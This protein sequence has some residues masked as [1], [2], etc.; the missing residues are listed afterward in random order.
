[1]AQPAHAAPAS[2]LS[3]DGSR[4]GTKAGPTEAA[5]LD[6]AVTDAKLKD[7]WLLKFGFKSQ[8][9]VRYEPLALFF[10]GGAASRE[11]QQALEAI[12]AERGALQACVGAA[13]RASRAGGPASVG[14]RSDSGSAR[15]CAGL[16]VAT[17]LG[18]AGVRVVVLSPQVEVD[19]ALLLA[20]LHGRPIVSA[21]W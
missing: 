12:A 3:P 18:Q 1:M 2:P 4:Y 11:A 10:A 19:A 6:S 16:A 21:D 20:L 13:P 9:R 5:L 7:G 17:S 14:A 15:C 8:F